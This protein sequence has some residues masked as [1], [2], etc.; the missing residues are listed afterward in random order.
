[1]SKARD[2]P[3]FHTCKRFFNA[4]SITFKHPV[5]TFFL[6]ICLH[7][8]VIFTRLWIMESTR[9]KNKIKIS[10]ISRSFYRFFFAN[11]FQLP[12]FLFIKWQPSFSAIARNS[13]NLL[14]LQI[15]VKIQ[16]FYLI[17]TKKLTIFIIKFLIIS[18]NTKNCVTHFA[19]LVTLSALDVSRFQFHYHT[20]KEWVSLI[21]LILKIRI[22]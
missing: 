6:L 19:R 11:I 3:R 2:S 17:F 21:A 1:M 4:N 16:W 13:L 5:K 18:H 12:R 20:R 8:F 9:A 14:F 10:H 22:L 15:W 7:V